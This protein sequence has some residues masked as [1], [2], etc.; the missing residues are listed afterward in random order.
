M[1]GARHEK[2]FLIRGEGED[3]ER[4]KACIQLSEMWYSETVALD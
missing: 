4:R 2:I 1:A 3:L